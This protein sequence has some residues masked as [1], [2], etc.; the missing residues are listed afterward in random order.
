MPR[1]HDNLISKGQVFDMT[2]PNWMLRTDV[3]P[4]ATNLWTICGVQGYEVLLAPVDVTC[5]PTRVYLSTVEQAVENGVMR[6]CSLL[7]IKA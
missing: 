7:P 1:S 3:G 2:P 4:G 5:I 6:P